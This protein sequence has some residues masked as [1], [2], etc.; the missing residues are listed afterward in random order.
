MGVGGMVQGHVGAPRRTPQPR[1]ELSKVVACVG[2]QAVENARRLAAILKAEAPD[3]NV[4]DPAAGHP[5][6]GL[7]DDV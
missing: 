3:V 2:T 6:P 5:G 7:F 1:F 4:I